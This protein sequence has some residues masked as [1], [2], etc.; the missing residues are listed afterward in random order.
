MGAAPP[1]LVSGLS[2]HGN[3]AVAV[4]CRNP[5]TFWPGWQGAADLWPDLAYIVC[6]VL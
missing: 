5:K 6:Q 4:K 2:W 3:C 1:T